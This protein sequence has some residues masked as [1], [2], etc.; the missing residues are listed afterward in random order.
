MFLPIQR[1]GEDEMDHESLMSAEFRLEKVMRIRKALNEGSYQVSA[2]QLAESILKHRD[3]SGDS[4]AFP[5]LSA[6]RLMHRD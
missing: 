6:G 1:S 5:G 2:L 3:F 4:D